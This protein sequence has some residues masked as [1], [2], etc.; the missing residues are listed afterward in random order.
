[1]EMNHWASKSLVLSGAYNFG[2]CF[3]E[4]L[5]VPV[6][7]FFAGNWALRGVFS[8]FFVTFTLQ[9]HTQSEILKLIQLIQILTDLPLCFQPVKKLQSFAKSRFT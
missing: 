4:L 5:E 2:T 6:G 9:Q 8:C 7:G 1:M 3:E